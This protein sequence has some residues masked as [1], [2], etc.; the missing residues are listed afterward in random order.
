MAKIGEARTACSRIS[1][2][3]ADVQEMENV[4]ERE[5]VLLAEGNIQAVV[6]G[7]RL[8]FKIEGA[9][10]AFSQSE[11]PGFVDACAE[12]GM[13]HKLHAAAFVK[14]SLGDN[15]LLRGNGAQDRAAG[16][17]VFNSLLGPGLVETASPVSAIAPRRLATQLADGSLAHRPRRRR[18]AL[19]DAQFAVI[20]YSLAISAT[21]CGKFGR[22]PGSFAEPE[23]NVRR[24]A[25]ARLPPS[26]D[27]DCTRRMRQEVFP[28]RMMSPRRLST[29]K[30]SSTVP[31]TTSS[32]SAITV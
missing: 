24:R 25:L 7:R 3:L 19:S 31:T 26:T 29:A 15:G 23:R 11:A 18:N 10:K 14:E 22:A 21:C 1:S 8:Q 4:G 28:R 12:W 5:T 20:A 27:P 16:D 13:N 6:G 30:S 9:A 32:G 2:T 17:N